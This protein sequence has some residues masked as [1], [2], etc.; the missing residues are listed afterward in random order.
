MN[1]RL[2]ALASERG[3]SNIEVVLAQPDRFYVPKAVDLLFTSNTYHHLEDRSAYF[4]D[5]AQYLAPGGRLAIV[6]YKKTGFFHRVMGHATD[7][8]AIREEM[9]SAGYSLEVEHAF[10][11]KQHF[12]IFSLPH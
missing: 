10:L 3:V 5:A 12:V 4:R 9:E 8:E 1:D 6:E 2:E 7:A 11:E